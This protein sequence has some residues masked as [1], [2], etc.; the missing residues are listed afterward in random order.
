V[1]LNL[2]LLRHGST[3]WTVERRYCGHTDVALDPAGRAQIDALAAEFVLDVDFDR[4]Y[5]S[6]LQRCRETATR[7]G[8]A[9]EPV[10]ALRELDFGDLEGRRWC[11]LTAAEQAALLDP[12]T[13][14]AP[15]GESAAALRERV[16][17]FVAQ[18]PDGRHLLVTHGGVIQH[19]LRRA[20]VVAHIGPGQWIDLRLNRR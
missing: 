1:D 10:P 13:F 16:D 5:T 7:L 6:D 3:A 15:G 9:A 17:A 12:E 11:D 2:C 4:V 8:V 18:L 14:V 20:G 19:L